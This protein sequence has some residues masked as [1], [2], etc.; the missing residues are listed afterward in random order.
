MLSLARSKIGCGA[1]CCY[2]LRSGEIL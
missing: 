1:R 2:R